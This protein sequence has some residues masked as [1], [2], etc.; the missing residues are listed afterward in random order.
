GH[1]SRLHLEVRADLRQLEVAH[2]LEVVLQ[3]G[4]RM[5]V[6]IADGARG[7]A[8]RAGAADGVLDEPDGRSGRRRRRC[9]RAEAEVVVLDREAVAHTE[10][11]GRTAVDG[12]RPYGE[13][14]AA[15]EAGRAPAGAVAAVAEHV[16]LG[17]V[18]SRGGVDGVV[19]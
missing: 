15:V 19:A 7:R 17:R 16:E 6:D 12:P 14:R 5:R 10:G 2:R 4:D 18:P 1:V 9:G 13:G 8:V 11:S 3:A